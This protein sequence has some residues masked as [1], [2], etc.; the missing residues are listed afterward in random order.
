[1]CCPRV[2][3]P[4]FTTKEVGKGTG[5]GLSQVYGFAK[6]S[7]GTATI[8]STVGRG[9]AV[10][11]VPAAQPGK[12]RRTAL[13][14]SDAP[15]A[16]K[17]AGTVLLV[18][19]NAEVAEVGAR[20]S[21]S[22]SA[23]GDVSVERAGRARRAA[24]DEQGRSRIL[25]HPDAGRHERA[26]SRARHPRSA[27]RDMP[28]LLTTGLQLE[29]AGRR[30]PRLRGAAK[31]LRHRHARTRLD[32]GAQLGRSAAPAGT[33]ARGGMISKQARVYSVI[34]RR[35]RSG[36]RRMRPRRPGRRPSR[37]A[38]RAP[39]DDGMDYCISWP[40]RVIMS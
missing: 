19:D 12:F 40:S 38:S 8:T 18:E 33:A 1:M 21:R 20:L 14:P 34:L 15:H 6:Q 29:R 26:R 3:E 30:A 28:V 22:S 11:H 27:S 4:F 37:R 5:L 17:R 9:T 39:Q 32:R 25:R 2:F 24:T 16:P 10:T 36:P 31:A 13:T 7:G 35:P 23:T